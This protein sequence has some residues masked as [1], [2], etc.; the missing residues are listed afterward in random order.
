MN[1]RI[2][3]YMTGQLLKLEAALLTLPMFVSLYYRENCFW[4]YPATIAASLTAG[5]LMTVIFKPGVRSIYAREGFVTVSMAW[6]LLPAFGA[7][8]FFLSGEIPSYIDALFETVSGFTTTG[9]SILT[10]VEAMSRSLLFWRSFTHWVGGMGVLVFIMAI[11]PSSSDRTIHLL[12]A[13]MPG[14]TMGKLVPKAKDTAKIL[15]LIYIAMT[16]IEIVILFIGGMPLYDSIVL[17]FG[18]AGTGGFAIKADGIASYSAF[19]QWVI[20]VFMFLFGI[21]FNLYYLALTKK[22]KAMLKS[23]ELWTYTAINIASAV[24]LAISIYPIYKNASDCIRLAAFQTSSLI[25]TTGYSTADFNLW[26]DSVR[27]LMV[28]LLFVGGCAGS[29]AG[30][31]KISRIIMLFKIIKREMRKM[32]HPRSVKSVRFEGKVVDETTLNSVGTYFAFYIFG[33]AVTFILI[34][35]E[36]LGL[37]TNLTAA[38]TCF[39]NV[40]PGLDAVGPAGSFAAFSPY[41]KLVLTAAMLLGRLEIYPL[42]IAANPSTWMKKGHSRKS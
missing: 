31:V 34:I 40:G 22:F 14:P 28:L 12:R 21:N 38:I 30:G 11:I 10:D 16:V 8:P 13:E 25:T 20:A 15:Y 42:I 23:E 18:T 41:A 27:G 2:C 9:A 39:N 36:P 35:C 26:P 4:V 24:F 6:V 17:S 32:L 37:L 7:L 3:F 19:S 29:T 5:Y 33:I 1:R